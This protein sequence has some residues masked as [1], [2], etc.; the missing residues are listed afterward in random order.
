MEH[1]SDFLVIGGGIAGLTFALEAA[2]HGQ[3]QV[4]CK[5][6]ASIS[7][8]AWAQGGIAAVSE[9]EE[10]SLDLHIEDTLK[11]GGGI[12]NREIVELVIREGPARVNELIRLG[13]NFDQD[14]NGRFHLHR[15]GG[16]SRRRIYHAA[17]ATGRVIH[18]ALLKQAKQNERIIFIENAFAIDLISNHHLSSNNVDQ[19]KKEVFGAYVLLPDGKISRFLARKVLVA[20][21]GAGKVY[22]YTSNPDI[23]TGDGIAMCFRAGAPVANMEFFQFHPTCLFHPDAKSFLIS[24]ALRGEGATLR[25]RSGERFMARYDSLLELAP[26][27]IVARAI[28]NEL[29]RTGD[30]YVFLDISHR[31]NSFIC[32][33]FPTIYEKC[34]TFGIDITKEPIPVV[35]AAHFLC[36]GVVA[37]K[38][39]K[40]ELQNLYVA[41]ECASSGLHGANRLASNS[42]LE[43]VVFGYRA[44]CDAIQSLNTSLSPED[45]IPSIPKWNVGDAA[46]SDE[47]VIVSQNWDELRQCMWNYVGIVRSNKRLERALRRVNL[48]QHE[49]H[50]YF[51]NHF[52]TSDLLELRNLSLVAE[53]VIKSSIARKESRG[54]HY[55]IDYLHT[56]KDFCKDTIIYPT[57]ISF[58]G[59]YF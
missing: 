43:G 32:S 51:W 52:V 42:L 19:S 35:P 39:G 56:S 46:P 17:D 22:K 6:E 5:K 8:T 34:K 11:T 44:A 2:K 26:R 58:D 28:D 33:H 59:K 1:V 21:G 18:E 16:H 10:D 14:K 9:Q 48:I 15:E 30:D 45:L 25:L 40:T 20:T 36:G 57:S 50:E 31:E 12:A 54:L 47:A 13:T 7:S 37:D 41:G 27:D 3:V 55:N 38:W 24:E 29:K 23:A 4:L 53:L 49:I